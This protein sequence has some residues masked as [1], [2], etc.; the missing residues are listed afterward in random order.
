MK[1]ETNADLDANL[2]FSEINEKNREE[3]LS[4][5]AAQWGGFTM[6]LRGE[7]VDMTKVN[8]VC[9]YL[10]SE[11]AGLITYRISGKA[12]EVTSFDSLVENKGIGTALVSRAIAIAKDTG[13]KRVQL[14][15]TNDNVKALLFYQKRGFDMVK[16][17]RNAL[18]VSRKLKPSIP[19][20]GENGI[21][22]RH[23]IE[24][25]MTL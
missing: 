7:T 19:T 5:I 14:I 20:I 18:D 2:H 25:E 11:L 4:F 13:C 8:G 22:L 3:V 24:M 16:I 17:N 12:L 21:P 15:T 23:E 6:I 1:C 10:G 9:A